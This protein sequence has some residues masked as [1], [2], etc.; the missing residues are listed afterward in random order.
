[1][2]IPYKKEDKWLANALINKFGNPDIP[3]KVILSKT[4]TGIGATYSEIH[5]KRNSIIIEPNIPVIA[6]KCSLNKNILPIYGNVTKQS[7]IVEYLR[8]NNPKFKKII[9]TPESFYKVL[10]AAK[11][12]N[13]DVYNDYFILY[14][15]CEK[16]IQDSGFRRSIATPMFELLKFKQSAVVSATP[17]IAGL[18]LLIQQGFTIY[19]IEPNFDFSRNIELIISPF[20]LEAIEEKFNR[21]QNSQCICIFYNSIRGINEIITTLD[22][23]S[24]SSIF[25]SEDSAKE[26]RMKGFLNVYSE[27]EQEFRKYNFFTSRFYSAVDI[28]TDLKPDII[29]LTDSIR[30]PYSLIDPETDSIQIS[31]RFRNSYSSISHIININPGLE[32]LSRE[33]LDKRLLQYQKTYNLLKTKITEAE[34]NDKPH[35]KK[36]FD[37]LE[38]HYYL[39]R[40][41]EINPFSIENEYYDE[42]IKGYYKDERIISNS[43]A[44]TRHFYPCINRAIPETCRFNAHFT[45]LPSY[46]KKVQYIVDSIKEQPAEHI[47]KL[48]TALIPLF[49]DTEL[50]FS[51]YTL[52][53]D[54]IL[55]HRRETIS[56]LFKCAKQKHLENEKLNST[57]L[58]QDV[59]SE[60]T[61]NPDIK[62]SKEDA[63]KRLEL[64]YKK[65]QIIKHP[66]ISE[67][68]R[69]FE[70]KQNKNKDNPYI[71]LIKPK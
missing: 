46:I 45:E 57:E 51:A 30:S 40:N 38:Y 1:M 52:L 56:K 11:K 21:L 18:D 16:I 68:K 63:I 14:D 65:H 33:E 25:C 49:E 36:D 23:K 69:F 31:G 7:E 6:G 53:G 24:E 29:I 43:Y 27:I 58:K 70:I 67:L 41:G 59:F 13:I 55:G 15:E 35:I 54:D 4:L 61:E 39:D 37:K 19:E 66:T 64:I 50:I 32:T 5:S 44:R 47:E 3:S 48:K 22:I 28:E 8:G 60:F 20:F 2:K 42:M 9:T 62:I 34:N 12:V 71:R 26:L 17:I 10:D